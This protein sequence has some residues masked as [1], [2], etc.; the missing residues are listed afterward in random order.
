M[1]GSCA[2]AAQMTGWGKN[3][4]YFIATEPLRNDGVGLALPDLTAV[5]ADAIIGFPQRV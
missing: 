3:A 2:V 4:V 1:G 5:G